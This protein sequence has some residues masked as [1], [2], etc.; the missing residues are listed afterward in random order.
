M[1]FVYTFEASPRHI[2]ELVDR[3][4][5]TV[6]YAYGTITAEG[7]S[8]EGL[9]IYDTTGQLLRDYRTAPCQR[10]DMGVSELPDGL[11]IVRTISSDSTQTDKVVITQ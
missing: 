2:Q 10:I 1:D 11:Y 8:L 7:A 9:Q 6:Q 5:T 4:T 3:G